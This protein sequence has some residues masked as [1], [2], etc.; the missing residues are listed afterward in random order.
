MRI[1]S[2]I[3]PA[4]CL[5]VDPI[6]PFLYWKSCRK[7]TFLLRILLTKK[8]FWTL[9]NETRPPSSLASL[10]KAFQNPQTCLHMLL[11]LD[12]QQEISQRGI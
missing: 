11:F 2:Q 9:Q 12:S 5:R 7:E 3:A 10:M 6:N 4:E 1:P 8:V